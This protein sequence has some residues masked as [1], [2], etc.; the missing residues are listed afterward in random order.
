MRMPFAQGIGLVA[1]GAIGILDEVFRRAV[2]S[3]SWSEQP[4]SR[5]EDKRKALEVVTRT[6]GQTMVHPPIYCD[7]CFGPMGVN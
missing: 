3:A 6:Q 4:P 1:V 2:T 5:S 7:Y